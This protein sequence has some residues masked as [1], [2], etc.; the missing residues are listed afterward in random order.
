MERL[1]WTLC[2]RDELMVPDPAVQGERRSGERELQG[3]SQPLPLLL[4]QLLTKLH[5]SQH[6]E[7]QTALVRL[8]GFWRAS[9]MVDNSYTSGL[10]AYSPAV[11]SKQGF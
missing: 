3:G 11:I 10:S 5:S 4:P 2:G 1:A 6:G 8:R 9:G 7:A